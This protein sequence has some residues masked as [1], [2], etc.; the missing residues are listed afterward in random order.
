MQRAQQV[1]TWIISEVESTESTSFSVNS[2][3]TCELYC[4]TVSAELQ[5]QAT[6]ARKKSGC[7]QTLSLGSRTYTKSLHYNFKIL[8]VHHTEQW[9]HRKYCYS[10]HV[11]SI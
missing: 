3:C 4:C 9:A 6:V 11:Q 7:L 10:V 2:C 1:P 5:Y 8:H